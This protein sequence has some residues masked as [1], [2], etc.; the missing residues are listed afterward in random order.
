MNQINAS[1]WF[2]SQSHLKINV[3]KIIS[4]I[5]GNNRHHALLSFGRR[6][7]KDKY[8]FNENATFF[9]LILFRASSHDARIVD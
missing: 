7:V 4:Q 9:S 3:I 5:E 8:T 2:L 6:L 1:G